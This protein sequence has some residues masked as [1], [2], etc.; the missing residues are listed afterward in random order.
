MF[1]I[2]NR[3][4]D[5][6]RI[7]RIRL[8]FDSSTPVDQ[9][10]AVG[11]PFAPILPGVLNRLR[12]GLVSASMRIANPTME[13][14]PR[15]LPEGT[16]HRR[17]VIAVPTRAQWASTCRAHRCRDDVAMNDRHARSRRRDA[18]TGVTTNPA[19]PGRVESAGHAER[20][21]RAARIETALPAMNHDEAR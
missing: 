16:A 15:Q 13:C 1:S 4:D 6:N 8:L 20:H 21:G 10:T 18:G 12:I 14:R 9:L 2:E 5:K 3:A 11:R 17:C 7:V 19:R